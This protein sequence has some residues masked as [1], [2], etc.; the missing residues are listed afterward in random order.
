[1]NLKNIQYIRITEF[2]IL[3]KSKLW[4]FTER[5]K[6]TLRPFAISNMCTKHYYTV[7]TLKMN[8][9]WKFAM[10]LTFSWNCPIT[11]TETTGKQRFILVTTDQ[12]NC[13]RRITKQDSR[14]IMEVPSPCWYIAAPILRIGPC[15]QWIPVQLN[16]RRTTAEQS[17]TSHHGLAEPLC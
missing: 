11:T 5:V 16:K 3:P 10:R 14:A 9:A 13:M 8:R 17:F 1:M 15:T 7:K 4:N 2:G 12:T 6:E